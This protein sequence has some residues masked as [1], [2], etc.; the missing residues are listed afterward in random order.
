MTSG[1]LRAARKELSRLERALEKLERQESELHTALAEAATDHR[2]ILALNTELQAV[3]AQK[4]STEEQWLTLA[5]RI[6]GS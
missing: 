6:E 4:D 2:R 3:T 1:E 5:S